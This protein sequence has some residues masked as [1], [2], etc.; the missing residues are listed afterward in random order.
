M[1]S[2]LRGWDVHNDKSALS[3]CIYLSTN[4]TTSIFRHTLETH[5]GHRMNDR[6]RWAKAIVRALK[7]NEWLQLY[8][9]VY[10]QAIIFNMLVRSV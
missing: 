9:L 6:Q 3:F 2:E 10:W 1:E 8:P 4:F 7:H 5:E